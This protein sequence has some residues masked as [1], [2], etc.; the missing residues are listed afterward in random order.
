MIQLEDTESTDADQPPFPGQFVAINYSLGVSPSGL[1]EGTGLFAE[2]ANKP[3]AQPELI[4]ILQGV[5][6]NFVSLIE[7]Y[8]NIT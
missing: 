8:F 6:P 3:D 7:P 4:A 2:F 5:S 1:P